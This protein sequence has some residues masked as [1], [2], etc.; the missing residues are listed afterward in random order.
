MT[1]AIPTMTPAANFALSVIFTRSDKNTFK[2]V[3]EHAVYKIQTFICY[4]HV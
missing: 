1:A 2:N 3:F 4:V